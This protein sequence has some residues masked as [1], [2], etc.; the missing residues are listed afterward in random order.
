MKELHNK[1]VMI[2]PNLADDPLNMQGYMGTVSH[3]NADQSQ[4]YIKFQNQSLGLYDTESLW[5]LV[6]GFSV[7]D[8][9]RYMDE[10][11]IHPNELVD[12]LDIYLL[13]ATGELQNQKKALDQAT[14]KANIMYAAVVTVR[15]WI[16][17]F[18]DYDENIEQGPGRGR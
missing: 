2:A 9:L 13:D 8:K 5:M 7:V 17:N 11:D 18:L 16:E 14:D 10:D 6:P 1:V 12:L 4:A 3:F 15:D